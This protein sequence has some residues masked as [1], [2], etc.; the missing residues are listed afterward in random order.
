MK[1]SF[2]FLLGLCGML[3]VATNCKK[4]SDNDDD[5]TP[6]ADFYFQCKVD[7]QPQLIEWTP[8]N[9]TEIGTSNGGS[10]GPDSC[11]FDYGAFIGTFDPG[12]GPSG[13]FDL[14]AFFR[15]ECGN[16]EALFNTLF[17][18]GSY[19]YVDENLG[20]K[21]ASIHYSPDGNE[22]FISSKGPQSGAQFAITKSEVTNDAFGL[23][24]TIT[25]TFSCTV[26]DDAGGSI[27]LTEGRFR[28]QIR[29]Y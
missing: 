21:G 23:A 2:L 16:E 18:V 19:G 29:E 14:L 12:S 26:Y 24:Q 25:G 8:T 6:T 15:G 5:P 4:D 3:F 28:L 20:G 10:V 17:P 22:A 9:T 27:A 13:G 11:T 1:R 7:G